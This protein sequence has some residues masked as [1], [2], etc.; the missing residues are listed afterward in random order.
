LD[1]FTQKI[2]LDKGKYY[3]VPNIAIK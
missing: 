3:R 2:C 1:K